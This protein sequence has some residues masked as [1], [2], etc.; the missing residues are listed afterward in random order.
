MSS[1]SSASLP[2]DRHERLRRA[3]ARYED[4]EVPLLAHRDR[5]YFDL[6]R[7]SC[8]DRLTLEKSFEEIQADLEDFIDSIDLAVGPNRNILEGFPDLPDFAL[9]SDFHARLDEV[10]GAIRSILSPPVKSALKQ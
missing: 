8:H 7:L 1:S 4:E 3:I 2:M 10:H 5:V 6:I 9:F